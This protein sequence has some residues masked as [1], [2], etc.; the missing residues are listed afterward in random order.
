MISA[1]GQNLSN[2]LCDFVIAFYSLV[3]MSSILVKFGCSI[4]NLLHD[5]TVVT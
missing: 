4:V 1:I 5:E 2:R 3:K